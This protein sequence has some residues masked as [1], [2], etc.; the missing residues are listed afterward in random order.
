MELLFAAFPEGGAVVEVEGD[1]RAVLLGGAGDFEAELA[2]A[3][4]KG[5]DKAGEMDDLHAFFS[6]DAVQIEIF[7]VENATDFACAVVLDARAA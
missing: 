5:A 7:G 6:K 3:F 4:G 2:C 1:L